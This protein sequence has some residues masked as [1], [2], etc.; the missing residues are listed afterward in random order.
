MDRDERTYFLRQYLQ[1]YLQNNYKI[2]FGL[3]PLS[4][5]AYSLILEKKGAYT[6][7]VMLSLKRAVH[8]KIVFW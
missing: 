1:S 5:K 2:V 4:P 3:I 8:R 6:H 7:G